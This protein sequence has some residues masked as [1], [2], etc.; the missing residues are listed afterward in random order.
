MR[1]PAAALVAA[2]RELNAKGVTDRSRIDA[3]AAAA[4]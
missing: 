2:T 3:M 1:S 4:G